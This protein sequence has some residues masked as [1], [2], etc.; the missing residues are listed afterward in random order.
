M[1]ARQSLSREQELDYYWAHH[2]DMSAMASQ[3]LLHFEATMME[4]QSLQIVFSE[5]LQDSTL[6]R[7]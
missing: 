1:A 2:F 3:G 7:P 5:H 6:K 4:L